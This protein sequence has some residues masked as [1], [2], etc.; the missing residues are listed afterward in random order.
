M[1]HAAAARARAHARV[2]LIDAE[3]MTFE[4]PFDV[5]WSVESISH[6][7]DREKFFASAARFLKPGGIIALTDWFKKPS[8]SRAE[9]RKYIHP[10]EQ[11]LFVRLQEIDQYGEYLRSDGTEN[12]R[13]E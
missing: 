2:S 6:Y 12:V 11:G 9:L 8:L 5:V 4:R 7:Q 3:A 10:I 13:S 1:A